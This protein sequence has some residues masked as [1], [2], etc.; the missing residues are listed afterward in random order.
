LRIVLAVREQ[1]LVVD[2]D[3]SIDLEISDFPL[4]IDFFSE[5]EDILP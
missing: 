1:R 5:S 2:V 3:R 4:L